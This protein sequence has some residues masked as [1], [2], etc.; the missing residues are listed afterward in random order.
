MRKHLLPICFPVLFALI[1]SFVFA[2]QVSAYDK[3]D[4][5]KAKDSN[6]DLSGANLRDAYLENADLSGAD[7]S[8]A[9]LSGAKLTDADL[10]NAK[11]I[12]ANLNDAD[13]RKADLSGVEW[14]GWSEYDDDQPRHLGKLTLTHWTFV[15][16][17]LSF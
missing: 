17:H 9:D 8:D 15:F 13:L 10:S 7:L 16:N 11:L 1:I 6:A 14:S 12:G 2:F 3:T 4:F 5:E